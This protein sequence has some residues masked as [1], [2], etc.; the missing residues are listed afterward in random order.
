MAAQLAARPAN[1]QALVSRLCCAA[2]VIALVAHLSADATCMH[3]PAPT[4]P[5]GS[6]ASTL[7]HSM[8]VPVASSVF[9]EAVTSGSPRLVGDTT[10]QLQTAAGPPCDIFV[11]GQ[12]SIGSIVAVPLQAHCKDAVEAASGPA[13]VRAVLYV[14][15]ATGSTFQHERTAI[16]S[17]ATLLH[18]VLASSLAPGGLLHTQL[19]VMLSASTAAV[20]VC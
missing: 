9:V 13:P 10:A 6:E 2:P 19:P 1:A 12:E 11:R 20:Q 8:K 3:V 17:L 7:L 5:G 18:T 4:P 15:S 16:M 14:A